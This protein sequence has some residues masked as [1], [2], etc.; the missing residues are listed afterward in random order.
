MTKD[1][2]LKRNGCV[3]ASISHIS[4]YEVR[5][6]TDTNEGRGGTYLVGYF[7]NSTLAAEA[8]E[9]KGVWGSPGSV[10]PVSLVEVLFIDGTRVYY[11]NK[12][13]NLVNITTDE[14]KARALAKLSDEDKKVLG[15]K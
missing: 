1:Q 4:A 15:V 7:S 2:I 11:P 5:G 8:A 9:S 14:L 10:S 3:L 13:I 6:E 12:P